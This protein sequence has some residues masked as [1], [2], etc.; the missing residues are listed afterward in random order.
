MKAQKFKTTLKNK[1]YQAEYI[2]DKSVAIKR[3]AKL[4]QKDCTFAVDTETERKPEYMHIK[5]AA[6]SPHLGKIRL[7]QLYDGEKAYVFDLKFI[8]SA[9]IFID[10]LN[11]KHFLAHNALFDL[12]F[13]K[14]MGANDMNI[15][16]TFLAA[17]LVIHAVYPT[18]AGASASLAAMVEAILKTDI[19][20]KMQLSDWSIPELTFEQVEYAALDAVCVY[21]IAGPLSKGLS[22]YGLDRVYN[23]YKNAQHPLAEMQLNGMSIDLAAHRELVT[24]WRDELYAAKKQVLKLTGL[25]ELTNK[26]IAGYLEKNLDKDTLR[27]WPRTPSGNSLSTSAPVL[28]EFINVPLVKPFTIYQKKEKL[29]STFG[30]NLL[31]YLNPETGRIHTSLKLAGARTGRLSS[32][33]P[34]LQQIPRDSSMRGIF[35]SPEGASI[36]RADYNQIEIR[37][38]AELSQDREMLKAYKNGLDIHSLTASYVSGKL[39]DKVSAEDRQAAKAINFGNMFGI[40][41]T[42]FA[43]Y[44]NNNYGTDISIDDAH[45]LIDDFR[46]LYSGYHDWQMAQARQG[47]STKLTRTPCGK[48][49]RLPDDNTYGAAMNTPIQGG[50]GE[51]MLIALYELYTTFKDTKVKLL[52]TIHDEVLLEVPSQDK[53]LISVVQLGL[54]ECM[55]DGFTAVFPNGVI[56]GLV[57]SDYGNTWQD[58]K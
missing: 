1:E 5:D 49:R 27:N 2:T 41:A 34:N 37:V 58:A 40:G 10:F 57:K 42:K 18:D 38:G 26:R 29:S 36:V 12:M 56:N 31:R 3:I 54:E 30:N 39:I 52:N 22:K 21:K 53:N 14:T 6:L 46:T 7:I 8:D 32:A 33:K 48:L 47:A 9:D 4:M 43:V 35:I 50:A 16:C 24:S 23:I 45:G 17:K 13:F 19:L 51:V 28:A 44:A 25:K 20:K 55:I 15:G 11:A